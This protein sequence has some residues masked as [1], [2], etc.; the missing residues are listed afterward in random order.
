MNTGGVYDICCLSQRVR[1]RVHLFTTALL[2][3]QLG[4]RPARRTQERELR[5]GLQR[6]QR[7]PRLVA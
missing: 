5:K 3:L 6:Q 7:Q 2:A 1:L 4:H